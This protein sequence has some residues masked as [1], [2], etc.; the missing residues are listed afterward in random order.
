MPIMVAVIDTAER[1][2][3]AVEAIEAI[4]EDGLIVASDADIG[5]LLR[6]KPAEGHQTATS[7]AR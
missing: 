1:I 6:C 3:T 7:A 2:A 5:R 4:V